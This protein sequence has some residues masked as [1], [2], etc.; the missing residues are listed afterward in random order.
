MGRECRT[1]VV[2]LFARS[3]AFCSGRDAAGRPPSTSKPSTYE[4]RTR[5]IAPVLDVHSALTACPVPTVAG[6][7]TTPWASERRWQSRDARA[8][9]ERLLWPQTS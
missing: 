8:L 4:S 2:A 7:R 9:P 3:E 6:V 1:R 5:V